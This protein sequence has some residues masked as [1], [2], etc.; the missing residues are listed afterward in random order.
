MQPSPGSNTPQI[1]VSQRGAEK[2]VFDLDFQTENLL[3]AYNKTF[4][5]AS[6][7]KARINSTPPAKSTHAEIDS[8]ALERDAAAKEL[9]PAEDELLT[10]RGNA[11]KLILQMQHLIQQGG[12]TTDQMMLIQENISSLKHMMRL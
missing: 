3:E 10:I 11:L 5:R 2:R 7:L 12:L 9:A 8:W 6:A 1:A 4:L